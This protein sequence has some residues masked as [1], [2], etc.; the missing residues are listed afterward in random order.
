MVT[1]L[2]LAQVCWNLYYDANKLDHIVSTE[3]VTVGISH[4]AEHSI[5]CFRGSITFL[6][7]LRDFQAQMVFD[8]ELGGVEFGFMQGLRR[9]IGQRPDGAVPSKPVYITG[10]SLGAARALI[11]AALERLRG[12]PIAGVTV[13]GSPRPGAAKLK[14]ILAP[15]PVR[16]YKNR[17]DPVCELPLNIPLLDP[18]VHVRELIHVDAAPAPE[19]IVDDVWGIAPDHRMDLYLKA[20]Q[21]GA[22]HAV[23]TTGAMA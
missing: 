19:E 17:H 5:I 20:L 4:S 10:H 14:E 18:Y 6:D 7:W 8:D 21:A 16:V 1:D 23:V 13:F 11:F 15:V 9:I 3:G 12:L 22:G 2:E